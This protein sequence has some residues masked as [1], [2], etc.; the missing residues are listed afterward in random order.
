MDLFEV[1]L[2]KP[3][4]TTLLM[5]VGEGRN[6]SY[7]FRGGVPNKVPLEVALVC[8]RRN[9]VDRAPVFKVPDLSGTKQEQ[10]NTKQSSVD[11]RKKS[12]RTHKI[13]NLGE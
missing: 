12:G 4:G 9:P 10:I 5:F 6:K 8:K 11:E 1:T 2:L 3:K 7:R 13:F